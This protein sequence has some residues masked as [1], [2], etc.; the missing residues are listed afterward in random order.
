MPLLCQKKK[1]AIVLIFLNMAFMALMIQPQAPWTTSSPTTHSFHLKLV[2]VLKPHK[3]L[4]F[5][6]FLGE[7]GNFT[8]SNCSV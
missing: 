5:Y 7:L 2:L 4:L 3:T 1:R 8:P 6:I